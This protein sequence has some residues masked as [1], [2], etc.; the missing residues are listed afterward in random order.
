MTAKSAATDE[1]IPENAI[2]KDVWYTAFN[3]HRELGPGLFESAY[4]D[5]FAYEM[6][7]L[8]YSVTCEYEF[9][10]EWDGH[11]FEKAFRVDMLINDLVILELKATNSNHDIHKVQ[12]RTYLKFANKRLGAVINFGLKTLKEGFSRIANGMPS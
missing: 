10:L 11:T 3:I 2:M 8:G 5:I 9:S 4:R 1:S 6:R 7:K 12:L